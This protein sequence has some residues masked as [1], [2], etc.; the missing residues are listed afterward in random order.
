MI[1]GAILDFDGTLFDSMHVWNKAGE[2]YLFGKGRMPAPELKERLKALSL[3]QSAC[4]LKEDYELADSPQEIMAEINALVEEEYFFTVQPKVGVA[5]FLEGLRLRGV[6]MLIATATERYQVEA[7]LKRCQLSHF[8]QDILTCTQLGTSKT[9]PLIFQEGV[10]RLE[11]RIPGTLVVED[12]LHAVQTAVAAGFP[13]LAV[14]DAFETRQEKLQEL[15]DLYL[16]SYN[17]LQPVWTYLSK[18][19]EEK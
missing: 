2:R 15:A 14:Y 19:Q 11:S 6:R 1:T 10:R 13:T 8:F 7:A 12:A 18:I 5:D 4:C 3:F 17:N 9:E 16:H